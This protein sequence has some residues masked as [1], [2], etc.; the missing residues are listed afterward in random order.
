MIWESI[1]PTEKP[2]K[3]P[4]KVPLKDPTTIPRTPGILQ[5]VAREACTCTLAGFIGFRVY[6]YVP[7][8]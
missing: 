7:S 4:L 8:A 1:I 2:L 5:M 6:G 3:V